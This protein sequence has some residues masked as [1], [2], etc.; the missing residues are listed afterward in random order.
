MHSKSGNILEI[1]QDRETLLLQTT[2]SYQTVCHFQWPWVRVTF[3]VISSIA[4]LFKRRFSYSYAAVD[5]IL[6]YT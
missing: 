2:I 6:M 4:S 3:S 5:S 1:V